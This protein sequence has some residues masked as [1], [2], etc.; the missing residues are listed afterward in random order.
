MPLD[1]HAEWVGPIPTDPLEK[2]LEY[3]LG[4]GDISDLQAKNCIITCDERKTLDLEDAM[5]F[6]QA[7]VDQGPTQIE[8]IFLPGNHFGDEGLAAIAWAMEDGALPKLLTVD[9]SRCKGTDVGFARFVSVIKHCPRFRDI[10]FQQN[11]LG[12][13]GFSA[14]HAVLQRHEW[15]NVE[16]INLAGAQFA[17]HTISDASFVPFAN[18][19]ADGVVKMLRLEELEMS[20][21]DIRDAGFAAIAVAVQRGNLRKLRSLYFVSNLITDGGENAV[22][23]AIAHNKR[24]KLLDIRL[25]YQ[26]ISDSTG[27]RITA[28]GGKAAIRAAGPTFGRKVQCILAPLDSGTA[29]VP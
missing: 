23:Q 28:E 22:A 3:Q 24:T 18:D 5:V 14:L 13:E 8:Y 29:S 26:N 21:N 20:D 10:I 7:L 19:L 25:G 12:D 16:R 6:A 17:R 27:K 9:F 15:P 4:F 2:V 1:L 11:T